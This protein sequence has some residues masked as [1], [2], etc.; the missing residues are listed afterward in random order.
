MIFEP[1]AKK[2]GIIR[3][4]VINLTFWT[5]KSSLLF[6]TF[7]EKPRPQHR[8]F[9]YFFILFSLQRW[10]FRFFCLAFRCNL[11]SQVWWRKK[12]ALSSALVGII[13]LHSHDSDRQIDNSVNIRSDNSWMT[14]NHVD[15][16]EWN[17]NNISKLT[18]SDNTVRKKAFLRTATDRRKGDVQA[19][20]KRLASYYGLCASVVQ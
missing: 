20:T 13:C 3:H 4:Y 5:W 10:D 9:F 11:L 2:V 8:D 14:N 7:Q 17:P 16:H 1:T 6:I 12:Y 15:H 18:T 19:S